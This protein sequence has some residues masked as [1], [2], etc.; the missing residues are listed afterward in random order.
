MLDVVMRAVV[1]NGYLV[2]DKPLKLP[3]GCEV[4]LVLVSRTATHEDFP[5]IDDIDAQADRV[6]AAHEASIV[7]TYGAGPITR[8]FLSEPA[9]TLKGAH[10]HAER[11]IIEEGTKGPPVRGN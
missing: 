6:L 10:E 9:D 3:D 8:D 5:V 7:Q 2:L 1:K 11:H 4:E